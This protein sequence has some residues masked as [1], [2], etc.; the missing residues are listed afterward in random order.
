MGTVQTQINLEHE[1]GEI[2][3][4]GKELGVR[5]DQALRLTVVELRSWRREACRVV[6]GPLT[7]M[8]KGMHRM[9]RDEL[10]EE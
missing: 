9:S 5:P 1:E 7:K 3:R 8:P 4:S 6:V 2:G 10:L